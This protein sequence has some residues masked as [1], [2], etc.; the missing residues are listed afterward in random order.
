MVELR[1]NCTTS[2]FGIVR[3]QILCRI[4]YWKSKKTEVTD[5]SLSGVILAKLVVSGK[6]KKEWN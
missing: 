3:T 6:R 5:K 2:I 1:I 4:T